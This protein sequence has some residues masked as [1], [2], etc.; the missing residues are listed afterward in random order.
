LL[1]SARIT[2]KYKEFIKMETREVKRFVLNNT[3]PPIFGR[4]V[5]FVEMQLA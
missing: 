5:L 4:A 3:A 1:L 2:T